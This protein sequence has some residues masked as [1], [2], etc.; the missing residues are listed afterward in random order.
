MPT[1]TLSDFIRANIEVI[2]SRWEEFAQTIPGANQ[3]D[4]AALR[5]HA[6]GILLTIAADLDQGQTSA[7]QAAKSKGNAPDT[8]QQTQ[9]TIVCL[10]GSVLTRSFL[11]SARFEP[12]LCNSGA[13]Q[14]SRLRKL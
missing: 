6:K 2:V 14:F 9:A 12:A 4:K 13:I 5:D 10:R 11:N 3:M 1:M 7:E 8:S